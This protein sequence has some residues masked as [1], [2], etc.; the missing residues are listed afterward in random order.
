MITTELVLQ[1]T[2]I[3]IYSMMVLLGAYNVKY[4]LIDQKRYKIY[5]I[6]SFYVLSLATL[7]SRIVSFAFLLDVYYQWNP[8]DEDWEELPNV[9]SNYAISGG[10][11]TFASVTKASLGYFQVASIV[12]L[13][14]E[15]R[16][17]MTFA[18]FNRFKFW[19][20]LCVSLL[21]VI[22]FFLLCGLFPYYSACK[23]EG[24]SNQTC[25]N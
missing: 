23:E 14:L 10:F 8:D 4:F 21:G 22:L 9:S 12:V 6:L 18:K 3:T 7:I 17:S 20:Q 5:F 25:I 16:Q 19:L 2:E 24:T 13:T 1:Y 15:L 11:T